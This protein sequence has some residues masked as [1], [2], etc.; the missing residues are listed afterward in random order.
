MRPFS[1]VPATLLMVF[2]CAQTQASLAEYRAARAKNPPRTALT[3]AAA[4][5]N[6]TQHR[7][8][9][10]ELKGIVSGVFR[11]E[12]GSS[13]FLRQSD[14]GN[15]LLQGGPGGSL[16]VSG[17]YVRA[18]AALEPNGKFRLIAAV[19]EAE[20]GSA[21]VEAPKAVPKPA[22]A[23]AKPPVLAKM[24]QRWP[25]A[26]HGRSTL[27]SRNGNY[28][29]PRIHDLYKQV[30]QSFNPRLTEAQATLIARS[31]VESSY[32]RGVD[33]RF[34]MAIFATESGFK[35]NAK[36]RAGAMGIGQLM[37]GTA[38]DLGVR[39]AY[40]PEQN[41]QGAVKLIQ[42]HWQTYSQKT[43]DFGKF[44]SLVCAAYNAGPGAVKKYGGVPPYKETQNYIVKV[45]K[46]YSVFAP[47]LF[48]K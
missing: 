38:R 34:I 6:P 35:V 30:V 26:Q 33:A 40:D 22:A 32:E 5:A 28:V 45:A 12:S 29:D 10:L 19:T 48:V 4:Q 37:P 36:S 47:E 20:I 14:G 16:P 31:I 11:D 41:I 44:I 24:P 8:A 17:E 23:P 15:V 21:E 27:N 1:W 46:W 9:V 42:Q 18:L 3:V 43:D 2:A 13:M 39:N 25:V 7:S